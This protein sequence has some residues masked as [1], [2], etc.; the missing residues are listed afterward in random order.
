M[1][2]AYI[3][4]ALATFL[5]FSA[6]AQESSAVLPSYVG[7]EQCSDCHQDASEAWAGSHHALAWTKPSAE[8]IVADFDGTEFIHDGVTTNFRIEGDR[9]FVKVT[10]NDGSSKE[11]LVHSVAGIEPLQQYLLETEAGRLQSF[12]V[13][14]D[15][16]E[17]RWFHLYPDQNLPPEDGLHWTGPYKNWNARCAECH[18]TGYEKNYDAANQSYA[19]VQAEI[20]VGCE[21][22]HGPG[23]AHLKWAAGLSFGNP[24]ERLNSQGL[25]MDFSAGA[26]ATIQQCASCHSRREG[27]GNGSPIPGTAY[28]EAYVLSPLRPGLYYPDGQILDEVYVYGSF[29]QSKMYAKGVSCTNCH[30]AHTADLKAEGNGVCT[31]CHSEAENP[32]FPSLKTKLYDDPSHHF[33]QPDTAGAQCK[34]CHMIERVYMGVDG[35]RDH[36]FRIPRPDVAALTGSP[37]ACTD[38]HTDRSPGWAAEVL[39]Q[40]YPDS[41]NRKSHYG[42]ALFNGQ[43]D[44]RAATRSLANLAEDT[45]SAGLVR[46]TALWLLEQ[47]A[48]QGLAARLAP[49]LQDSD[50]LVRS[51]AIGVQ[52]M[53]NP[54]EQVQR[55]VGLL[56]DPVKSVRIAAAK[57]MLGAPIVRLPAS[58]QANLD[59]AMSEWQTGLSNR[60]DF[61][62]THLVLGGIALSMRNLE[63]ADKAFREVTRMDPQR[64]DAWVM[65]SRIAEVAGGP[66]A[67]SAVLNEALAVNPGNETLKGLAQRFTQDK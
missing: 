48:D 49:M 66:E 15:T 41:D 24:L 10:E 47:S 19:S 52:R 57:A 43:V 30:E 60:A 45:G 51:A 55:I 21:A 9:Y 42:V 28:H 40:K 64:V 63:R 58:I 16:K 8:T 54:S 13:V 5:S 53:A 32:D 14:W 34:S 25:T 3:I 17:K 39:V 50:P 27:Q 38:C 11:Y 22:C 20:G 31:Q 46:A 67:G 7:S 4:F 12:D 26:E 61:P 2:I 29:L 44:P 59:A 36:S 1:R 6:S 35:R 62:E 33:H 23:S 18:S 37:D 56:D 65:L